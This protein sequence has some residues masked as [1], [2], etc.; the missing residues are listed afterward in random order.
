[1][2][3][4][5]LFR[6]PSENVTLPK[7]RKVFMTL[8]KRV[9]YTLMLA[10]KLRIERSRVRSP[11]VAPSCVLGQ[12]RLTL[13]ECRHEQKMLTG[14]LNL[15]LILHHVLSSCGIIYSFYKLA[16]LFKC[17][18]C[19]QSTNMQAQM[20]EHAPYAILFS[21]YKAIVAALADE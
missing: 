15:L 20:H 11:L 19:Y 12:D 3:F 5:K 16:I 8:M 13:P 4:G 7:K 1:M 14:K 6:E 10:N 17:Y 21:V 18:L 2:L 9:Q